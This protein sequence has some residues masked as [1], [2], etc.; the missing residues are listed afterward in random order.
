MRSEI[1]GLSEVGASPDLWLSNRLALT[2]GD[3]VTVH[4]RMETIPLPR[5]V[6]VDFCNLPK[7]GGTFRRH[8]F[9]DHGTLV[10][11]SGGVTGG[12]PTGTGGAGK[13]RSPFSIW[14]ASGIP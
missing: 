13:S 11:G 14:G 4:F 12:V 6:S 10:A 1:S 7:S 3:N 5:Q 8:L 9:L 2:L